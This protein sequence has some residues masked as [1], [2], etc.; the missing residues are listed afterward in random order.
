MSL[1]PE[2]NPETEFSISQIF[3]GAHE[4][5]EERNLNAGIAGIAGRRPSRG[6]GDR[7]DPS[8]AKLRALR[9]SSLL[10]VLR[11]RNR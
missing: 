1:E 5:H 3:K 11:G 10:I 2:V 9:G 4:D 8:V 6:L 7:G